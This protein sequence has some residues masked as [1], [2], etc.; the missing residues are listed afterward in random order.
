[1]VDER[2]IS[3]ALGQVVQLCIHFSRA[4]GITLKHPMI[5]NGNRSHILS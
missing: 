1:M 5:F 4:L 2:K 3:I